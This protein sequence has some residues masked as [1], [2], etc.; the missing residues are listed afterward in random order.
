MHACSWDT[1]PH[2]HQTERRPAALGGLFICGSAPREQAAGGQRR[3][4]SAAFAQ[5]WLGSRSGADTPSHPAARWA[6]G[7]RQ[8]RAGPGLSL[9]LLGLTGSQLPRRCWTSRRR[10]WALLAPTF[11]LRFLLKLSFLPSFLESPQDTTSGFA[12]S[13]SPFPGA[14]KLGQRRP[15]R[16]HSQ[17]RDPSLS[18]LRQAGGLVPKSRPRILS[19]GC[20]CHQGAG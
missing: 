16:A 3:S 9:M 14:V 7:G 15:C 11:G 5:S 10:R 6:P 2:A 18:A 13:R 4:G 1:D 12:G 20:R 17:E 19:V 8:L